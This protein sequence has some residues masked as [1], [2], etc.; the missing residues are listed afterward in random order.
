VDIPEQYQGDVMNLCF[1]YV[2]NPAET[3]G[4]KAYALTVLGNLAKKYPEIIPEVKLLIE[5]QLPRQTP[6]FKV[7]AKAFLKLVRHA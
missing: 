2:E 3:V 1:Q 6:A 5:D 4:I 7:R